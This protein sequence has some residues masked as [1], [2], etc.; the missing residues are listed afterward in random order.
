MSGHKHLFTHSSVFLVT[1]YLEKKL[2]VINKRINLSKSD[3]CLQFRFVERFFRLKDEQQAKVG[4]LN[5]RIRSTG[6]GVNF[7]LPS[8]FGGKVSRLDERLQAEECRHILLCGEGQQVRGRENVW[9]TLSVL[10]EL[11]FS[12]LLKLYNMMSIYCQHVRSV[13]LTLG[14]DDGET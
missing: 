5:G 6:T 14:Q 9:W 7:L 1:T 10:Q 2:Q 8:S 11:L 13:E 12:L 3:F 4:N